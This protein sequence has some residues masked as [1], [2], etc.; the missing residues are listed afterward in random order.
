MKKMKLKNETIKKEVAKHARK[1]ILEKSTVR[2]LLAS[3]KNDGIT[4]SKKQLFEVLSETY[5]EKVYQDLLLKLSFNE[6]LNQRDQ[7]E[8]EKEI[9][10][11]SKKKRVVVDTSYLL[12]VS[13]GSIKYLL[14]KKDFYIPDVVYSEI[15]NLQKDDNKGY[16]AKELM[17]LFSENKVRICKTDPYLDLGFNFLNDNDRLILTACKI[18]KEQGFETYILTNDRALKLKASDIGVKSYLMSKTEKQY[19]CDREKDL[20]NLISLK[21]DITTSVKM[22]NFSLEF[23]HSKNNYYLRNVSVENIHKGIFVRVINQSGEVKSV[24]KIN[25]ISYNH[26]ECDDIILVFRKA[27]DKSLNLYTLKRDKEADEFNLVLEEIP[28]IRSSEFIRCNNL[29]KSVTSLAFRTLL[30]LKVS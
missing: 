13:N 27:G 20:E 21:Q 15:Q 19:I 2:D 8:K 28:T 5:S 12:S 10:E 17:A 16:F 14:S 6:G 1:L 4:L 30:S 22:N 26:F 29:Y 11:N 3:I 9:I 24:T 18:F 23:L 7:K 25:A